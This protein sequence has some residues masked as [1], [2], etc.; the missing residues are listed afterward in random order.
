MSTITTAILI[1]SAVAVSGLVF[2]SLRIRG[3]GLGP[4]GVLFSGLV[5]AHFGATINPEIN[6]FAKEFGLILFVF[7]IGIQ[8]G[9]GIIQLW[10]QQGLLLNG[11][12]LLIVLQGFGLVVLFGYLY[13]FPGTAVAGLFSGSTTNTPSLGA[14]EQAAAMMGDGEESL[15]MSYLASAY[16]VAYPGGILGIIASMLLLKKIFKVDLDEEVEQYQSKNGNGHEPI[17][18]QSVIVENARLDLVPFGEIPGIDET[19]V[20]L[21]RV[22][23]CDDTEVEAATEQT[24]LGEGDVIQVVGPRSGLARFVPLIGRRSDEDLMMTSGNVTYRRVYV[25]ETHALNKSLA[26][27]S[28]DRFYN[29]T[30]TRIIRGGVEMAPRG[31][32]RLFYG[33]IVQIVGDNKSLDRATSFLGNSTKSMKETQFSP[34]FVGIAVGVL[35]GMI[36]LSIPGVPFPVRLGLAGGPLIAAIVL[37]L[38]G[39]IG[40]FVWYIPSSANLALRELGIILFLACAGLGAGETFFESAMSLNGAKWISAGLVITMVPLLVAGILARVVWKQNYLTICGVIAGSMTDPPALAFA[41]SMRDCDASATA[42]AAVYPLTM[43]LRIIVAQSLI[44]IFA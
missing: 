33:D 29:V 3:I 18:R 5:F 17:E 42:Y 26:E 40:S 38:V 21:S 2:G 1:I 30:I 14:A 35:A 28:L 19:G 43:I 27:L 11:L 37:S 8:L 34:L 32:S 20:R 22:R 15:E 44:F 10:K 6:H 31:S 9:P 12:T 23:R 4:A 24:L 41:G 36:P 13:G 16:A 39:S 7:T 25:T